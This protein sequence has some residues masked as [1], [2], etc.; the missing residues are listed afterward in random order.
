[1][2]CHLKTTAYHPQSNGIL[3]RWH[4]ALKG[5]LRKLGGVEREWDCLLKFCLL[6]YRSTPHT[7]TGFSPFELVH[8]YPMRGPLE[9]IK[10][11]WLQGEL[12]LKDTVKWVQDLRNT[13]TKLHEQAGKNEGEYKKAS[14]KYYDRKARNRSFQKGD[15]VLLHTPL[16]Q[17]S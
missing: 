7:A 3:E 9:A 8:G 2:S 6:C 10:D 1:M 14:K 15:M 5:M 13:M 4:G 12:N 16:S 11:G 17:E